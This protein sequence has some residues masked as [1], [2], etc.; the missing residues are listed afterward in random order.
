[1]ARASLAV[2]KVANLACELLHRDGGVVYDLVDDRCLDVSLVDLLRGVVVLNTLDLSLNDWL[3]FLNN[4]L[5][6]V[7]ADDGGVHGG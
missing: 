3:D 7:F 5:V 2:D 1:M 4:M 6:D